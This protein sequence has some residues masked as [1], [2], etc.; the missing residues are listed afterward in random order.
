MHVC[1]DNTRAYPKQPSISALWQILSLCTTPWI[2]DNAWPNLCTYNMWFAGK[3]TSL[4]SNHPI[5][6][7]D[8]H[9]LT[10]HVCIK[11][12]VFSSLFPRTHLQTFSYGCMY[13][14]AS[15]YAPIISITHI[16]TMLPVHAC[17]LKYSWNIY[18]WACTKLVSQSHS[19][20]KRLASL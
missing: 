10:A 6:A 7:D 1:I 12:T 13:R 3:S 8:R 15:T 16:W 4:Q 14:R 17:G 19:W 5:Y 2:P 9:L 18:A 20:I 11:K